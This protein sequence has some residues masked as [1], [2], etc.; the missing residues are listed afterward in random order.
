M[1]RGIG[2]SVSRVPDLKAM[3]AEIKASRERAY[4]QATERLSPLIS[5][6][7]GTQGSSVGKPFP[8][9]RSGGAALLS[10]AA[11]LRVDIKPE[12]FSVVCSDPHASILQW[13]GTAKTRG[14]L[15]AIPFAGVAGRPTDYPNTFVKPAR[16][17]G[18]VVFE[19]AGKGAKEFRPIFYLSSR[20][21]F[22]R[23]LF[24]DW[25]DDYRKT[26]EEEI[27]RVIGEIV[28]RVPEVRP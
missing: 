5:A 28:S 7:I 3:V 17:G 21:T 23:R 22:P 13:G 1:A 8:P 18:F 14:K 19:R 9:R 16:N 25:F 10:L 24:L 11:K 12:R 20:I 4:R 27:E 6:A 26:V 2:F 15:F